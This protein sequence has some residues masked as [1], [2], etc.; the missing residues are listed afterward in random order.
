M[1]S[2]DLKVNQQ[3]EKNHEFRIQEHHHLIK[4]ILLREL[5]IKDRLQSSWYGKF[6]DAYEKM[7]INHQNFNF[8]TKSDVALV[9]YSVFIKV[10]EEHRLELN[11]F[12]TLLENLLTG[13][14]N[15][16][17]EAYE[18]INKFWD[19]TSILLLTILEVFVNMKSHM[20]S[21]PHAM[22]TLRL[23][24]KCNPPDSFDFITP[25]KNHYW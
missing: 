2:I 25:R 7:I 1:G 3:V 21:L 17:L 18:D 8:L 11:V 22:L 10:H 16:L 12:Q 19:L 24:L 5:G 6:D 9:R 13:G 23:I 20:D 14:G 4:L 15:L